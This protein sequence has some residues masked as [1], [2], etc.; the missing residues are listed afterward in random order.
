MSEVA[1]GFLA[2]LRG[3]EPLRRLRREAVQPAPA[4]GEDTRVS[5][6]GMSLTTLPMGAGGQRV[7]ARSNRLNSSRIVR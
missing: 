3:I 2:K 4:S 5:V 6:F 1:R 7:Q